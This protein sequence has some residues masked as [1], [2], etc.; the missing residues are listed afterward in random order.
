LAVAAL[1]RAR[2]I[3]AAQGGDE[4]I[5]AEMRTALSEIGKVV[6]TVYTDDL[7]DRIFS[8]FCIGK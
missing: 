8:S 7:L 1:A 5:A 6:G 3:A 2:E 4:L